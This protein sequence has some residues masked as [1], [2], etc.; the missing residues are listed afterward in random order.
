MR[1]VAL[2]ETINGKKRTKL[3]DMIRCAVLFTFNNNMI[4]I[5]ESDQ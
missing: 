2:R 1:G 3:T 5:N 4:T